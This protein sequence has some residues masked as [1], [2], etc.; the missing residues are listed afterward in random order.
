MPGAKLPV[1]ERSVIGIERSVG[2]TD[3]SENERSAGVSAP[4]EPSP[5]LGESIPVCGAPK[6]ARG[7]ESSD[8]SNAS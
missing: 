3:R 6:I 1:S 4:A 5:A 7:M 2:D 8:R